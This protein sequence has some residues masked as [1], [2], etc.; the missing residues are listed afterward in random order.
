[1]AIVKVVTP[2]FRVSF[3]SVFTPSS[4]TNEDG[5]AGKPKYGVTAIWTPTKFSAKD[6]ARWKQL[7]SE[8]NRISLEAFKKNWKD[9]PANFKK[10]VRN[11]NEKDGMAG[12]GAG[13]AFANLTSNLKPQ[14]ALLNGGLVGPEQGN[15][16]MIYPG[17][18]MRAT[19]NAYSYDNRGKG[20]ALGLNNLQ[21]IKDGERLDSRTDAADDFDG[22]EVDD[23]W[24][25]SDD[26]EFGGDTVEP[27]DDDWDTDSA[28]GTV[29]DDEIPF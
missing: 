16:D 13:T 1:M 12:Y 6:K 9:L 21:F 19:V 18:Y 2:V 27:T 11:G 14:I 20:V 5:S 23:E 15:Q 29:D 28:G 26:G 10:G 7:M 17:C 4:M 24:L 8:L 3:P 22:V 25:E